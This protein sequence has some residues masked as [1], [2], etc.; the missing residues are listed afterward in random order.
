LKASDA[1]TSSSKRLLRIIYCIV[2]AVVGKL[3]CS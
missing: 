2:I 3:V 1:A